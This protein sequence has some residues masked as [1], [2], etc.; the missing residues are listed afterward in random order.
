MVL[1]V[2]VEPQTFR[3]VPPCLVDSPLKEILAQSLT[4]KLSHQAEKRDLD[5]ILD[6][7]VQLDKPRPD[8]IH[9]QNVNLVFGVVDDSSQCGVGKTRPAHPIPLLPDGIK[10]ETVVGN[11]WLPGVD[12]GKPFRGRQYDSLRASEHLQVGGFKYR[13]RFFSI[14]SSQERIGNPWLWTAISAPRTVSDDPRG[15]SCP[16]GRL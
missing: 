8:A 13:H 16:S 11:G 4:D 1:R 3:I 15:P 9:E 6:T 12:D 5:L 10:Q 2:R 14:P 7:P